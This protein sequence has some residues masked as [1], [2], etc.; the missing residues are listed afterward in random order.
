M[1]KAVISKPL[2][3]NYPPTQLFL[4]FLLSMYIT[5]FRLMGDDRVIRESLQM[6]SRISSSIAFG[7]AVIAAFFLVEKNYIFSRNPVA[8]IVQL[9]AAG[10]MIWARITFGLRSFH[11]EANPTAGE[12]VTGGPYRW[13]RHPIYASLIYFFW[14]CVISFPF[15]ETIAA[16]LLISAALFVRMVLEEKFLRVTYKDYAAYSRRTKRIIPFLF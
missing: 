12:L 3:K 4:F 7:I 6:N 14:A 10:L 2:I 11:K 15:I 5:L 13:L 8:I 1:E 16:A 9:C